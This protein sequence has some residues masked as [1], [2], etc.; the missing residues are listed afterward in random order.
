MNQKILTVLSI[1]I[2]FAGSAFAKNKTYTVD[3]EHSNVSFKIKHLVSKVRGDFT[4]FE[5]K[6]EFDAD[7]TKKFKSTG[8]I[9]TA[10]I[11]TGVAKR[12]DHLRS[13][14]FF[15]VDNAKQP[16]NKTITFESIKFNDVTE[17]NGEIKG[18]L[19]GK[20]TIHSV[21][22]PIEL[23]VVILG[24]PMIDPWG[25]ERLSFTANGVLN[26]KDFGLTWNKAVETGG[27]VVGDEVELEMNV[28]A[29]TKADA[30]K[31]GKDAE[32]MTKKSS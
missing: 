10:S 11:N 23:D 4:K 1:S 29:I 25:M 9:E 22:K 7:N 6:V 5:G 8:K 31:T 13:A 16:Q 15:D 20:I 26:R 30:P 24:K 3:A 18:K 28:E 17:T 32:K 2:L 27:F 14:D 12:D 19:L 21:T